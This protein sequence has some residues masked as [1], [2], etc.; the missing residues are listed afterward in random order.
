MIAAPPRRG[1]P[2]RPLGRAKRK[3]VGGKEFLPA[4]ACPPKPRRRRAPPPQNFVPAKL[5][6]R[7][8]SPF[9]SID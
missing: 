6:R 5:A 4:L 7:H 3:G 1:E 8:E 2:K 9:D